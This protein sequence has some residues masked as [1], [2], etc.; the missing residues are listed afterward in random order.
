MIALGLVDEVKSVL[1]Y[2]QLNA[3]NTVGYKEVFRYLEGRCSLDFAIEEIKKNIF[4]FIL[5]SISILDLV[6]VLP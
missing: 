3:L 6:M 1:E 5:W 4:F 2:K